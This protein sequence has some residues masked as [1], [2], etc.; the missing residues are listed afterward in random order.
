MCEHVTG[1]RRE[2]R[3]REGEAIVDVSA[4]LGRRS[5]AFKYDDRKNSG[6]LPL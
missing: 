2:V 5:G 6:A 3:E 4:E 1:L